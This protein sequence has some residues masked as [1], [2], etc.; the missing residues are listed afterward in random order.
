MKK[1]THVI[2]CTVTNNPMAYVE[3]DVHDEFMRAAGLRKEEQ[4]VQQQQ[5]VSQPQPQKPADPQ[6]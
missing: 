4:P 5:T 3:K 1:K 6:A 2:Y